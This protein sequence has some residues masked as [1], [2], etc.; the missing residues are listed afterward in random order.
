MEDMSIDLEGENES[1][2][3]TGKKPNDRKP[4]N[5][6]PITF[7]LMRTY[8]S[9]NSYGMGLVKVV[10]VV[11]PIVLMILFSMFV[12]KSP[13]NLIAFFALLA[14]IEFIL[15]SMYILCWILEKDPGTRAMQEVSD[16]IREGSEGFFMT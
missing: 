15:I 1:Q 4:A 5:D 10:A 7:Y 16:P 6:D 12:S 3:F 9:L 2:S 13:S 8:Y 11:V 14:S